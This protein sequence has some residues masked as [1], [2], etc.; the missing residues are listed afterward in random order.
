VHP[1]ESGALTHD[2]QTSAEAAFESLATRL[3]REPDTEEGKAFHARAIK[4]RG[5]IVAMLVGDRLVV[6]LPADRC[7]ELVAAGVA[8]PF[9]SG[10]RRMRQWVSIGDPG[11]GGWPELAD[12]ALAFGRS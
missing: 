4:A 1:G 10:G 5:K 2:T 8:E 9:E 12:E 7:E 3:L 11:S 6:K